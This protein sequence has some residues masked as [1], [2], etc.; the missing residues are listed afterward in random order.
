MILNTFGLE[1]L[2]RYT[3][4]CA[5]NTLTW[6]IAGS[7]DMVADLKIRTLESPLQCVLRIFLSDIHFLPLQSKPTATKKFEVL[8]LRDVTSSRNLKSLEVFGPWDESRTSTLV[9]ME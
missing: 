8:R 7:F 6:I 9:K 4:Y 2:S 3:P 5:I 1:A